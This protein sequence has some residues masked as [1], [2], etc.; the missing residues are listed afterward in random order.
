M[1]KKE[2][3]W[4]WRK[5]DEHFRLV[6]SYEYKNIPIKHKKWLDIE[7]IKNM[8]KLLESRIIKVRTFNMKDIVSEVFL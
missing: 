3:R 5:Y 2:W 6:D 1:T 4:R 7:D 8:R